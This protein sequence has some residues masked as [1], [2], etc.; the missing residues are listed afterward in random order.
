MDL[1]WTY[2]C[3]GQIEVTSKDAKRKEAAM[4]FLKAGFDLYRSEKKRAFME[5]KSGVEL[6]ME[7]GGDTEAKKKTQETRSALADVI[8][9]AGCK[10]NQTSADACIQQEAT[11]AMSWALREVLQKNPHPNYTDLLM[12]LRELLKGKYAQIPQMSTGRPVDM[13]VPFTM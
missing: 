13:N 5:L 2:R 4:D 8:Q 6:L 7:K 11:G 1:P 9:F 3:G 10:D 12:Q